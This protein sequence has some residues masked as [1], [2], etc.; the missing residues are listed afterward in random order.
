MTHQPVNLTKL[1]LKQLLDTSN[2]AEQIEQLEAWNIPFE[3]SLKGNIKVQRSDLQ[4][5]AE[6]RKMEGPRYDAD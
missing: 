4:F 3:I 5:S 6:K 2:H 1:E